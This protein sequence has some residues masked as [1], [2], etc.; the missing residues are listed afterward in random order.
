MSVKAVVMTRKIRDKM[1][2]ATKG[3]APQK[4][5]AHIR[6]QAGQFKGKALNKTHHP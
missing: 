1:Y 4:L 2:Q 6:Q 5:V 3:M